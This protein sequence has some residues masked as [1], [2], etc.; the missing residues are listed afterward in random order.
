MTD[1]SATAVVTV[2]VIEDEPSIRRFVRDTLRRAGMRVAESDGVATGL[3]VAGETLPD[4]VILDLGLSDGDGTRFIHEFRHWSQRPILVL[5]ARQSESDKVAALDAGADDFL[6]KPFGVGELL[7]RLRALL[8]RREPSAGSLSA[9]FHFSDVE[10]DLA[11]HVVKRAGLDIHLSATEFQ[12]LAVFL[13]QA[14][15]V[16]THRVLLHEVWGPGHSGDSHYLR[17]YVARLRQKLERNPALPNHL[18]TEIGVGY[19]FV[20]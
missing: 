2:L 9:L 19:R 16:L 12:L 11:R 4:L 18:L 3:I 17:I 8:R 20:L 10:V 6:T 1:T 14:G 7:A 13:S 15:K 5:S